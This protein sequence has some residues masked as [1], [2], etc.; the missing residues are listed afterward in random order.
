MMTSFKNKRAVPRFAQ[1]EIAEYFVA[2]PGLN[3][4]R[5]RIF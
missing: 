3:A 4:N 2:I 1:N 5:K